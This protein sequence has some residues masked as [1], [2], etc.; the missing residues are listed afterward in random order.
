VITVYSK[1]GGKNG[2][3]GAVN[4]VDHVAA[5]SYVEVQIYQQSFLHQFRAVTDATA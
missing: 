4:S 2:K 5:I 3:H 1:G